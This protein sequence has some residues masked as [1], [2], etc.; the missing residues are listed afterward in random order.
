M[1]ITRR[2]FLKISGITSAGILF[3]VFDLKPL[4][5]YA[6][7]HPPQWTTETASICPYC[8]CG[9]G[10]LVGSNTSDQITYVQGDPDHPINQGSLCSKAQASGQLNHIEG[11]VRPVGIP[12]LDK[13][14]VP[15]KATDSERII[16]PLKR[17][18][19]VDP[20]KWVAI[21]WNQALNDI[22]ALIKGERD[23]N[24]RIMGD[25]GV[26]DNA[27]TVVH[28]LETI[29]ALGT[30]KDTN[31][32]CYLFTKLMRSLGIVYIEH[33]ARV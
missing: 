30:A 33:C 15:Y 2:D 7:A 24:I 21:S 17:D 22:A 31:E 29:A 5:A 10:V 13:N 27:D 3:G 20:N 9:C 1:A 6:Q 26:G 28:R 11:Y 23:T 4:V 16:T 8:G 18:P 19:A 14:G 32:E 12:Y 25:T